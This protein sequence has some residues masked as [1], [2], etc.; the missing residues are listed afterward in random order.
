MRTALRLCSTGNRKIITR[1]MSVDARSNVLVKPEWV[2]S[3]LETKGV[4]LVD[5]SWC[6]PNEKKDI[7]ADFNRVRLPGSVLFDID[8]ICDRNTNLPHMLPSASQFNEQVS[9]LGISDDDLVIVYDSSGKYVASARVWWTFRV[10]G[11]NRVLVLDGGLP[12]WLEK[13]LPTISG[14]EQPHQPGSFTKAQLV[15]ELVKNIDQI[16][17][18]LAKDEYEV[19]DARPPDRF[20]GRAPEPRAGLKSGFIPGTKNVPWVSVLDPSTGSLLPTEDLKNL[21]Q[22]KGVDINKPL[23]T[24][25]GSGVTAS[26]LSLALQLCDKESAVYDGSFSEWGNPAL[27]NPVHQRPS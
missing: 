13:K 6:M 4:R 2:A 12:K 25:C 8:K 27:D 3:K 5:A 23:I 11:H 19:V 17:E 20:L 7:N 18:N 24:T 22:H 26:V 15:P 21:F 9:K 10:F 14:S 1:H 16:K